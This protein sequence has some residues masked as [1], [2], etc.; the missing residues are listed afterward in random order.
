[1][2]SLL[3]KSVEAKVSMRELEMDWEGI[4]RL[5]QLKRCRVVRST[6]WPMLEVAFRPADTA[7]CDCGA[8]LAE[9]SHGS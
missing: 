2:W 7:R 8:L 5:S 3:A 4:R 1:M 9:R 6:A